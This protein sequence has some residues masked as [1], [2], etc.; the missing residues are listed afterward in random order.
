MNT[1]NWCPKEFHTSQ[2]ELANVPWITQ[3]NEFGWTAY[4]SLWHI[5]LNSKTKWGHALEQI[6][7][8]DVIIIM[9]LCVFIQKHSLGRSSISKGDAVTVKSNK[10]LWTISESMLNNNT[11]LIIW[12][13]EGFKV[14]PWHFQTVYHDAQFPG[15][16]SQTTHASSLQ[17]GIGLHECKRFEKV[18]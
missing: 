10:I 1:W 13:A 8:N 15:D 18:Y 17:P 12:A 2:K 3:I 6:H 7:L 5:Y 9:A 4:V 11:L 14:L 16:A